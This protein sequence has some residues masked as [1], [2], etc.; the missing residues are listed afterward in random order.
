MMKKKNELVQKIGRI[1]LRRDNKETS[2][3]K[4]YRGQEIVERHDCP[5]PE[6][7]RPN[8]EEKNDFA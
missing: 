8:E 1:G 4:S 7:R 2:F 5:R 6:E 3:T